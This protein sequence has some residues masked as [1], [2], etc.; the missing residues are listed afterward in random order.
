MP[1]NLS[2]LA[3]KGTVGFLIG[4]AVWYGLSFP[5]ARL[6]GSVSEFV[7]RAAERPA[8]T[9][10]TPMGSLLAVDRSD[11]RY[12]GSERRLAV[13]TTDITFNVILMMTLFALSAR[14][15]SDRNVFG[16]VGA[17]TALFLVHAAAVVSF[18]EADYALNFGVWSAA[19][20]GVVARHFWTVA[21]YFYSVIGVHGSAFAIWWLF[22][23]PSSPPL[24]RAVR[25]RSIAN[26]RTQ[27][28]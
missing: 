22:R 23:A 10:I 15:L 19:H 27:S 13:E 20:Y 16:F 11:V 7:I 5:Y 2:T 12:T 24:A 3:I 4:L 1:K 14:P 28:A 21:P 18:V 25:Q 17:A 26:R 9:S 8:I 6:L